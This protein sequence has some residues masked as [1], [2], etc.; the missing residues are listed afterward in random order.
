M[1]V[2]FIAPEVEG[3][4]KLNTWDEIDQIGDMPGVTLDVLVGKNVTRSRVQ[5][6]LKQGRD[7]LL[8]AGHGEPGKFFVADGCL[9][10][11]WLARYIS[12]A[13]PKVVLL[14]SCNSA[15]HGRRTQTSLAEEINRAGFSV[16]AMPTAVDDDGAAIYDVEFVR[17]FSNG[18][19]LRG[20]HQIA[21]EQMETL[22][23]SLQIPAFYPGTDVT[24][25]HSESRMMDRFDDLGR[26]M[27]SMG[28]RMDRML[29]EQ[30]EQAERI[31]GVE[32]KLIKLLNGGGMGA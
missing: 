18:A 2:L 13:N 15:R 6:R 32:K 30:G 27:S 25:A 21:Q 8:F 5:T 24:V 23:D 4:P 1:K 12:A 10:S 9:T 22:T 31:G 16:I 20:A 28:H 19:D 3:L 17:A 11:H 7:V 26:Q 29:S 14:S